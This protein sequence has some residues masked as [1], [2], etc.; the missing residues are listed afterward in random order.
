[1]AQKLAK[2]EAKEK[3]CLDAREDDCECIPSSIQTQSSSQQASATW[4]WL[5][6]EE[7]IC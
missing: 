5:A 2:A 3:E 7:L 6:F 4:T 1:M